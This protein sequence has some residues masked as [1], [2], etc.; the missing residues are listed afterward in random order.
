MLLFVRGQTPPHLAVDLDRASSISLSAINRRVRR[1]MLC[2]SLQ[3]AVSLGLY[4]GKSYNF[5]KKKED[6]KGKK[7]EEM[8]FLTRWKRKLSPE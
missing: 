2:S 8:L 7:V 6:I 3:E 4:S 1:V 5:K